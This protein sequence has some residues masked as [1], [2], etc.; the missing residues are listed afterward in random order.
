[1]T[2]DVERITLDLGSQWAAQQRDGAPNRYPERW[3][4]E[5]GDVADKAYRRP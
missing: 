3:R 1:M 4:D 2:N 5:I